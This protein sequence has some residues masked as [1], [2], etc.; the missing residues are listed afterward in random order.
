MRKVEG[1]LKRGVK[2]AAF[3]VG[4]RHVDGLFGEVGHFLGYEARVEADEARHGLRPRRGR[5]VQDQP[6]VSHHVYV[7]LY[8]HA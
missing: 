8:V 2:D 3:G 5:V 4:A 6:D 7:H 1:E